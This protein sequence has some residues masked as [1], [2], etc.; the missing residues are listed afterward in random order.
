MSSYTVKSVTFVNLEDTTSALSPYPNETG[1]VTDIAVAE[2]APEP[3]GG[4]SGGQGATCSLQEEGSGFVPEPSSA[5]AR[6]KR[7]PQ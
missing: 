1:Y 6:V 2:K 5:S 3:P 4:L 7:D